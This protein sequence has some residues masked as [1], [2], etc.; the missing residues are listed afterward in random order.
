MLERIAKG[1]QAQFDR[2]RIVFWYDPNH[3]FR[4]VFEGLSLDGVEKIEVA[5]TE[6]AVKHRILREAPK[7]R[8]LLYRD[9]PRPSNIDN[10]L[11]DVELAHGIF[12]T[13]QVAIWLTD[14]GL[15]I[16]F[17][18]VVRDHQ[19]FFRS[20]RRLEKL[21]TVVRVDDTKPALRLRM[22]GVCTG[23]DGS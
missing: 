1:L 13:D 2:H 5:N 23:A 22:L 16:S 14:L 8:F 10:W 12:K 11:L 17:E 6:F 4:E 20:G 21:K 19:E 7:Q 15:P 3:E 9:G 18:D